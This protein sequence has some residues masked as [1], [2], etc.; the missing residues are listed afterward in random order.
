MTTRAQLARAVLVAMD[1]A[2]VATMQWGKDDCALWCANALRPVLG[3]DPAAKF[4]GRYRTRLG[5]ARALGKGGLLAALRSTARRH[6]WQRIDPRLAQPGDVGLAWVVGPGQKPVLAT[7]IC[8]A[9]GWFV[10]RNETGFSAQKAERVA[11]AWS[12]LR[13]ALPGGPG[14]RVNL[15][16]ATHEPVSVAM[17]L[18]AILQTLG[19]SAAVASALGTAIVSSKLSAGV[20]LQ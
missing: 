11:V 16:G 2:T 12:V 18:P 3:Y 8:R 15:K 9:R 4:R 14:P 19:F 10:G 5:A 20:S 7:V 17:G 6:D 13:D 1:A